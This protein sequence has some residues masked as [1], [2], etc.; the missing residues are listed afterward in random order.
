VEIRLN[1]AS[2]VGVTE[3]G[4]LRYEADFSIQ[5]EVI[6]DFTVSLI[7]WSS[8]DIDRRSPVAVILDYGA[9]FALE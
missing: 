4:R 1:F 6:R 8:Y 3:W 5:C 7:G 2:F 9:T